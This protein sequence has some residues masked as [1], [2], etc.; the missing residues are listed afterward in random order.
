MGIL[1]W[2]TDKGS[3]APQQT[4]AADAP[5]DG[6]DP[7]S[8]VIHIE[9]LDF[10]GMCA[11]SPS[12]RFTLAWVDGGPDQA[13][14]GRY[15]L[16]DGER[17][18]VEGKMARPNDGKVTDT[19]LFILNDWGSMETLNGTFAAFGPDGRKLVSRKFSANLYNNGL[20]PDGRF[21]VCQTANAPGKDGNLLTLFDLQAGKPINAWQPES[22]W[23]SYYEFPADSQ[24]IRLG[25]RDRGAFAYG[26]DGT[27]LDRM[28][29][30]AA[31]LQNG[32]I[33]ILEKILAESED[34]PG[35]DL[36]AQLLAVIHVALAGLRKDDAKTRA[37]LLKSRGI[38]LEALAEVKQALAA[39]DEALTLDPKVGVKRRADQLRKVV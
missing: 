19:G 17:L 23:A 12:K 18:I 27:F 25:Y 21:A 32:D 2:L 9:A 4:P 1:N 29:W 3:A 35:P 16:L 6:D 7:F 8:S 11:R 28:K 30:L 39:Y 20:S 10:I 34:Q 15:L 36:A 26:F 33:F 22:G 24:T 37:R 5:V 38:C 14:A 13:R 31:G